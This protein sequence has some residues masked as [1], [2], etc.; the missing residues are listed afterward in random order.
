MSLSK[1]ERDSAR[2]QQSRRLC[3][4]H[5]ETQIHELDR[6]AST[7]PARA[8]LNHSTR[9]DTVTRWPTVR[10][11]L[12]FHLVEVCLLIDRGTAVLRDLLI[13]LT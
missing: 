2:A 7:A 1:H 5:P 10:P 12:L 6:L 13:G 9:I 4:A 3:T 11:A 8:A